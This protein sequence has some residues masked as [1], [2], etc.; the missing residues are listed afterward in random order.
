MEEET[1]FESDTNGNVSVENDPVMGGVDNPLITDT[2]GERHINF[3]VEAGEGEA[4]TD[5]GSG[6]IE[7]DLPEPPSNS[8]SSTQNNEPLTGEANDVLGK[9]GGSAGKS[10][11]NI[12]RIDKS[13]ETQSEQP[14]KPKQQNKRFYENIEQLEKEVEEERTNINQIVDNLVQKSHESQDVLQGMV[15]QAGLKHNELAKGVFDKLPL[16]PPNLPS[17]SSLT[18]PDSEQEPKTPINAPLGQKVRQTY[19]YLEYAKTYA[20]E[21]SKPFVDLAQETFNWADQL[22]SIGDLRNGNQALET[23]DTLTQASLSPDLQPSPPGSPAPPGSDLETEQ[24]A[25]AQNIGLELCRAANSLNNSG[26]PNLSSS[27]RITAGDLLNF[28]LGLARSSKLLDLPLNLIEAFAG[29]TIEFNDSGDLVTRDSTTNERVFAVLEVTL[30]VGALMSGGLS[31]LLGA[32]ILSA[33]DKETAKKLENLVNGFRSKARKG[34]SFEI[35]EFPGYP[36]GVS[37]PSGSYKILVGNDYIK[38]RKEANRANRPFRVKGKE[39]HEIKPVKFGGNPTDP[40]NKEILSKPDHI[41]VTNWWRMIQR[42]IEG[43]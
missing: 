26:F 15:N 16:I 34:E 25:N 32:G 4:S 17:D 7:V 18:P 1:S 11:R 43:K 28:G 35:P 9:S 38:A 3:D 41:L 6:R 12:P 13:D 31:A 22:C 8:G 5:G 36:N 21:A 30:T 24:R 42:L 20:P 37:K 29:K 10:S 27:L 14:N 2:P 23:V 40:N 39:V 19:F 33:I